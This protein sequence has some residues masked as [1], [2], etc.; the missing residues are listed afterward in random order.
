MNGKLNTS[1]QEVVYK[2]NLR[3]QEIALK[4]LSALSELDNLIQNSSRASA[5]WY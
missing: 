4:K 5:S 3:D 1:H 2:T